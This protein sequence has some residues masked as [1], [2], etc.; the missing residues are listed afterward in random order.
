MEKSDGTHT[1]C[2]DEMTGMQALERN[3]PSKPM[4]AGKRELIEFE[5]T[6]NGT[7]CLIGNFQVTTGELIAPTI[8]PTRT[9]AD[10][11]VTTAFHL[12]S[13]GACTGFSML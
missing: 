2:V 11:G 12:P 8:G 1:V 10:L 6:R 4:I 13:D 5:Y 3:A 7:L 9:E